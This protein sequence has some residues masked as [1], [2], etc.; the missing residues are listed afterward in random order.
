MPIWGQRPCKG[1]V[2]SSIDKNSIFGVQKSVERKNH[3]QFSAIHYDDPFNKFCSPW[4][5]WKYIEIFGVSKTL[6]VHPLEILVNK[7]KDQDLKI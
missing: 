7:F 4:G 5:P 3:M 6:G 1:S 2:N